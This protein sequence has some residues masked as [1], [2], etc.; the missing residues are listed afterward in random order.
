M[1]KK[2]LLFTVFALTGLI[3]SGIALAQPPSGPPSFF[4]T[5][6]GSGNGADLGGLTG[7]DAI[8]QSQA[9]AAGL[10]KTFHAYLSTQGS[11]AVNARDRIGEG[12]WFN[13]NGYRVAASVDD[14]HSANHRV[15]ADT[16]LSATGNKIPW[17]GF[18]PNLHDVLTG[19]QEDGTAYPESEDMTCNNWTS[20]DEGKA[21][22]GHHDFPNWN[23]AHDSQNCS[24]QGL[25][26][27]GGD[28]LLY[29]FAL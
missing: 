6:T 2:S 7:A 5:A 26:N 11:N 23:S 13:V 19:S 3:G 28:G 22:V 29:C 15:N 1:I 9:D 24:R 12:P 4:I 21:R 10:E 18:S 20:N 8:C 16:G 27:F 25:I 17:T 14:L